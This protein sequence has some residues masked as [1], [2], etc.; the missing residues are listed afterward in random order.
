MVADHQGRQ[1]QRAVTHATWRDK[2]KKSASAFQAR[3][4]PSR[5]VL[6]PNHKI[7]IACS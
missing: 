4:G 1:Y 5:C 3:P 2:P 6:L 7:R